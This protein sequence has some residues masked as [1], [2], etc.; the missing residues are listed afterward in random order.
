ELLLQ[1]ASATPLATAYTFLVDGDSTEES[2]DFEAFARRALS[3]AGLLQQAGARGE[4]VLLLFPPGLEYVAAFMGCVCAGAIA[5]PA[6]PPDPSRLGRALPRLAALVA[7]ARARFALTTGPIRGLVEAMGLSLGALASL[8]WL[9]VEEAG[10]ASRA[11][12]RDPAAR[13]DDVA[14]LQYT[15]GST[16]APRG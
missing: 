15:S 9:A 13:A 3:V 7:D 5:V 11:A 1:R 2:L 10:E 12:W 16:G 14:L 4:P 8:T 6:Y